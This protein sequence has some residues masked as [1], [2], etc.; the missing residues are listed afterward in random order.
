MRI[1]KSRSLTATL[2]VLSAASAIALAVPATP[3]SADPGVVV[4]PGMEILQ[5]TN[6]CTLG[7]VD[8]ALRVAF[9]AGHCRGSG[10]VTDTNGTVIGN[11]AT[12][13]DNTPDG[14][15]VTTDQ[16][17]QDYE[18]IVLADN[19][20][21][22]NILPSGKPLESQPGRVAQPGEAV[23]HFGIMTGESC[24]SI[25]R[26]NDGWFTMASGVVSQKGDSGGPVYV[27]DGNRAV[28]IGLFNCTWGTF[29]A[30]VSWQSTGDQVRED[31]NV[32]SNVSVNQRAQLLAAH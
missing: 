1:L 17:I 30:A 15:T 5:D 12:F 32:V 9:T 27:M 3:A 11:M 19:V 31:V 24:G 10:P 20:S 16:T 4:H 21:V 26:V 22:N 2:A 8:P 25:D 14:A 6:V 29:P 7:Y 13:R 18:A 28:V 23:C